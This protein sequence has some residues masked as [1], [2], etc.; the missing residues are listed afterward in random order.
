M[1]KVRRKSAVAPCEEDS[2][3]DCSGDKMND[4]TNCE[5]FKG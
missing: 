4:V 1:L 3:A 5:V 2:D